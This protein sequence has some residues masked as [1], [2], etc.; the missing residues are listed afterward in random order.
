MICILINFARFSV[1]AISSVNDS[2]H[3]GTDSLESF[4]ILGKIFGF[5]ILKVALKIFCERSI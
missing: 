3:C 4:S 5:R 2:K 1:N